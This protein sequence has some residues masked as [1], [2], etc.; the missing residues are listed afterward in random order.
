MSTVSTKALPGKENNF[1][2]RVAAERRERMQ[3]RLLEAV[4]ALYQ[5]GSGGGIPSIDEVIQLAG[6]S[7]G[8]FYKY[9]ES[10][11]QAIR[12]L[13]K[14]LTLEMMADFENLFGQEKNPLTKAIGGTAMTISRA[15]HDPKYG[16]FTSHIDP[17]EYYSR[18][19]VFDILVR[20]CLDQARQQGYMD[21]DSLDVA[22]D[23]IVGTTVQ[24]R[25]RLVHGVENPFVYINE[26]V[27]RVFLGLGV[28]P[29]HL[30]KSSR[31]VWDRI[32]AFTPSLGWWRGS[33]TF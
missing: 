29:Q 6:V 2:S 22:F 10:V 30:D 5:P 26:I 33:E 17:I 14:R 3:A 1:R 9:F 32:D 12:V 27:Q 24:A 21:F 25:R 23:L 7:R 20:D 8:S 31:A 28:E 11:E 16:G 19:T 4:L 13:G 15:W 18:M